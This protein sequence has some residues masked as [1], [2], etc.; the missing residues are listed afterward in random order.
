MCACAAPLDRKDAFKSKYIPFNSVKAGRTDDSEQ[1]SLDD[2]VYR[3]QDGGLLDVQHDIEALQQIDAAE[4]KKRFDSRSG[5]T[6]WPY[7]SGVWSK[8]EWVLPVHSPPLHSHTTQPF[9]RPC[10]ACFGH[11][12]GHVTAILQLQ[13]YYMTVLPCTAFLLHTLQ[14]PA[15][16]QSCFAMRPHP[17]AVPMHR[18]KAT[19]ALQTAN[20]L[21]GA[22][23]K[24][25]M[26]T[27]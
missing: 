13:G 17:A 26:M 18:I 27:W 12:F 10:C 14:Q 9:P 16:I 21:P 8:K 7:G 22:C 6:M 23:S 19:C 5:R 25:V 4:W 1:Y 3:S 24:S 15:E 11:M 2:V 20:A